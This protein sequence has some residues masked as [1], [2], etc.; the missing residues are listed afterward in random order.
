MK[1]TIKIFF[2]AII[3]LALVSTSCKK[4]AEHSIR[5]NNESSLPFQTIKIEGS[6]VTF[7]DVK[8]NSVTEYKAIPEGTY[9]LSGDLPSKGTF[10]I[11]GTGVHKWSVKIASDKSISVIDEGK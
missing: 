8:A 9:S 6:A 3:A 5:I 10:E 11:S 4:P 2:L 7:T 1:R